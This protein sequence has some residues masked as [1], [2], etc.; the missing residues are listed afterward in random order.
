MTSSSPLIRLHPTDN[1][2]V[3]KAALSLGQDLPDLGLKV[4]AQVPAG[5]KIAAA[6]IA[7]GT[8]VRKYN[9]V[10]GVAA[11][12]I[13]P[14]E[15]VHTHNLQFVEF[16]RDPHFC[17]DVTPVDYL[18][19]TQQATFLGIVRD[20]GRVATRN[21]IG[22]LSSVNCSATVCRKIAEHF[23]AE[24][25]A[26]FPNVDGVVAFTHN[27][28]CGMSTP[29]L[30][31]DVFRRTLAG[32]A[33]HANLAA[34]LIIGLGCERNQVGDLLSSQSLATGPTLVPLIMQ[35]T[36]GTRA[37]IQAGVDA[38]T[39][40]LPAANDVKRVA[41]SAKHLSIGLQCGGS[42]GFSGITA[43]PALGAAMDILVRHGG[44]AILSETPEIYGVEHMLTR[45]AMTPAVGQKLLDRLAW[46]KEYSRG[47]SGQMN[48]VVV[49]GNQAGGIANIFEKSLGSAMKGGTTPLQAVYE[50]AEPIDQHGF[51]FMDSP[52]FDPCSATGQIASGANLIC[53]T[54]GRGSMFGAKPV[55]S[56]KLASNT[57][58]FE[59]LRDDM[60][61]NCG[62]VV[63]G[64]R[65]VAELGED[66][67]R[68]IL[69]VASGK[70]TRSEEL[71]LGD[72]EFV[73]W[74][75]GIVT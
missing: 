69:D 30:N 33:K 74:S 4:R 59:K 19:E 9:T 65:T 36:A 44:T 27:T 67:F 32:Y 68:E 18:P 43:N 14:G 46:W 34:V 66:I 21:Y 28:G 3:A 13:A 62:V 16:D 47:Q 51:V 26:P 45:R 2:L 35:D 39:A 17:E 55:P 58:M 29:S 61:I 50:Y 5:H 38:I 71:G 52:G 7:A 22:I 37:S 24:R 57:P 64:T 25:L 10:I 1:I 12:D 49:A 75:L 54:T 8:P 20:D 48:G 40:M 15:H 60:D 41:V 11:R 63:D 70:R 23:T 53:F 31:F 56:I 42:D 6:A 72:N 73:P